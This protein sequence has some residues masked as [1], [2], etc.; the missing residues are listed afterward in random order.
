MFTLIPVNKASV[1]E[2]K[3]AGLFYSATGRAIGKQKL[4]QDPIVTQLQI[5]TEFSDLHESTL[6]NAGSLL[7]H[8]FY[9][10]AS[11]LDLD[12]ILELSQSSR[13][14]VLKH[15]TK[16]I[17]LFV[18]LISGTLADWREAIIHGCNGIATDNY[19]KFSSEA[20]K[21]LKNAGLGILWS[22]Y[23]AKT[24]NNTIILVRH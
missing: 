2:A 19:A 1:D 12:T 23:T 21:A 14:K 18:C 24:T 6:E 11:V 7:Y 8:A 4:N 17:G 16:S 13:L 3:L 20:Y 5:L 15:P 9:S 22:D 10:A